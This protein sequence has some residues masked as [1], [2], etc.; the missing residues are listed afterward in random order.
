MKLFMALIAC[1]LGYGEVGLWLKSEASR[2][3]SWVV[4]HDNPYKA[5]IDIYSGADY[6]EGVKRGLGKSNPSR[7]AA[8]GSQGEKTELIETRA[9]A[10]VPSQARLQEWLTVWRQCTIL[11]K[12]F[13]DMGMNLS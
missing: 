13:W 7:K 8:C 12:G 2:E 11:E 5:W 9:A 4:L 1:L 3:G 6:Q 10:D